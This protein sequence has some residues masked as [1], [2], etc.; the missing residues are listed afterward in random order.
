[1]A[2][3]KESRGPIFGGL[4]T[5]TVGALRQRTHL[6][7]FLFMHL[8][9]IIFQ[10]VSYK[11]EASTDSRSGDQ[12]SSLSRVHT[13]VNATGHTCTSFD[14]RR[15]KSVPVSLDDPCTTISI[16]S[17]SSSVKIIKCYNR[18]LLCH[19]KLPLKRRPLDYSRKST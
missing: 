5:F 13:T 2:N 11:T 10:P 16:D 4:R 9:S 15:L 12:K 18:R 7:F 3:K 1:M 6:Q 14:L 8:K 17:V 19:T